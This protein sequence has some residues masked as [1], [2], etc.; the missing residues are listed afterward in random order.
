MDLDTV[1]MRLRSHASQLRRLGVLHAAVFGS[2]ARNEAR[3]G[4]DIDILIELDPGARISAFDYVTLKDAVAG[5]F[6]GNV[7]VVER[8]SLKPHLAQSAV[9]DAVDAF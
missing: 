1:L 5:L 6:D 8:R 7:D 4:S 3:P 2:T 9:R